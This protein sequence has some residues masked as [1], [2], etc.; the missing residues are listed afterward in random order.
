MD[1]A[2]NSDIKQALAHL[3]QQGYA[4]CVC[5]NGAPKI[6]WVMLQPGR[7]AIRCS[8]TLI[9]PIG[10]MK[11]REEVTGVASAGFKILMGSED[12]V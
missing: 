8:N 11:V 4:T 12:V 1:Q 9:N 3:E 6:S 2:N 10:I 7:D 5:E